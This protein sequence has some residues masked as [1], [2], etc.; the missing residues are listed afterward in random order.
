MKHL[1][2]ITFFVLLLSIFSCKEVRKKLLPS[3]DVKIPDINLN[4]PPIPF[5]PGSEVPVGALRTHINLDSAIKSHTGGTLGA[6]AVTSITVKKVTV[7]LLNGDKNNN[8]SNFESARMRIY[9]NSDTGAA[10]IA[11]IRFP[12]TSA[13][14]ITVT[15]KNPT[16]ISNYLKGS[17]LGYNLYW[18]NR[19][20]TKKFL[21]LVLSVT[22]S[23][24]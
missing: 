23:V 17:E 15:A 10:D 5:V 24:Q 9:S 20:T 8:L 3:F 11:V 18:K 2:G 16:E 22:L 12:E 14:S 1:K 19:R 6:G 13:Q 7:N 21:K 4:I